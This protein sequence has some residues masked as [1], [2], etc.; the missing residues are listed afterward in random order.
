[1]ESICWER[2]EK[3]NDNHAVL[4]FEDTNSLL[5]ELTY[6]LNKQFRETA[7]KNWLKTK[8]Q[9]VNRKLEKK[10]KVQN[11]VIKNMVFATCFVDDVEFYSELDSFRK[12]HS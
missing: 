8:R 3:A 2:L 12:V 6:I 7:N 11:I 9:S 4:T 1:M 5:F 10:I